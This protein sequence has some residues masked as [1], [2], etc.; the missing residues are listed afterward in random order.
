MGFSSLHLFRRAPTS[1]LGKRSSLVYSS[2]HIFP[3]DTLIISVSQNP[4][5][6]VLHEMSPGDYSIYPFVRETYI[7]LCDSNDRRVDAFASKIT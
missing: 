6:I 2:N 7:V 5:I 1:G 4:W 3:V